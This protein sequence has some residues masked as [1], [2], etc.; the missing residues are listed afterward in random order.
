MR[1][2]N[3]IMY[4]G[5]YNK[6]ISIITVTYNASM[7][8]DA[9]IKSV[10]R[11]ERSLYEYIIIDGASTDGTVDIIEKY[12]DYVDCYISEPDEGI[13]DAMNKGIKRAHGQ[14]LF[15]LQSGDVLRENI[16]SDIASHLDG[17]SSFVYGNVWWLGK[18][19]VYDGEFDKKKIMFR[20]ICHQAIFYKK[21]LFEKIGLY[22][23]RYNILG[24]YVFNLLCFADDKISKKYVDLIISNYDA[25]ISSRS[26]DKTWTRLHRFRFI[27][28]HYGVCWLINLIMHTLY[29]KVTKALKNNG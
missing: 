3:S 19:I 22:D 6:K 15:F 5:R 24:D 27:Y 23:T 1:K 2:Y 10:V 28:N 29:F 12:T 8:I 21:D 9:T 16:F 7:T 20:N 13:Y 18:N 17:E 26:K 14:Y 11:Q 4:T 25:G